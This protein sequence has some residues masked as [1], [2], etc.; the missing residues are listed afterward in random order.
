MLHAR[1]RLGLTSPGAVGAVGCPDANISLKS[2]RAHGSKMGLTTWKLGISAQLVEP[3]LTD[4]LCGPG[5]PTLKTSRSCDA[6][7]RSGPTHLQLVGWLLKKGLELVFACSR[8]GRRREVM[9]YKWTDDCAG[10]PSPGPSVA[11]SQFA[12][13]P[14]LQPPL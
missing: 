14:F 6:L 11:V 13:V 4:W 5:N 7:P 10:L 2:L 8:A 9:I 3:T 1:R 12:H